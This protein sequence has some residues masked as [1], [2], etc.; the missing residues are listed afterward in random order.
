[1]VAA[2]AAMG[3]VGM[4]ENAWYNR[5]LIDYAPWQ[6]LWDI[7]PITIITVA[8]SAISYFITIPVHNLWLK[9]I[10]GTFAFGGLFLIATFITHTFLREI[11]QLIK[12]KLLRRA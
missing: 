6:Q 5:K 10:A 7:A 1:M 8:V 3:L 2:G 9:L 11:A 12:E 4:I